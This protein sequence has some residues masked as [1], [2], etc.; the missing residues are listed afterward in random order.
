MIALTDVSGVTG[1]QPRTWN[2]AESSVVTVTDYVYT[3]DPETPPG[4]QVDLLNGKRLLV[5]DTPDSIVAA[6]GP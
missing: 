6:I 1:S 5:T 2:V 3:T 4:S